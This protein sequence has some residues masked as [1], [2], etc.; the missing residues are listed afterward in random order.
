MYSYRRSKR[1]PGSVHAPWALHVV[2]T[3][4]N[5]EPHDA[6]AAP[7]G[8]SVNASINHRFIVLL[9]K[10]SRRTRMRGAPGKRCN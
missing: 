7:A 5:A 2:S 9:L 4:Q 3:M 8:N 6:N 10:E 1:T